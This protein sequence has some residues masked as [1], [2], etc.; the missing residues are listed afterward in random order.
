MTARLIALLWL[1]ISASPAAEKPR[2]VLFLAA[3]DLRCD[4]A[5]Y[6]HPAA[7]TP[8]FDRLA[9]RSVVFHRAY[10]QQALCNPSRASLLTGKR[11]DQ[12]GIWDLPTHFRSS[13][14]NAL[15]I[16]QHFRNHGWF[17]RNLGKIFHNFHHDT[18]GD[19]ASWSVPAEFH[20]G[21]HSTD[22]PQLPDQLPPNLASDPK[23]ECRDIP[24]DTLIDGRIAAAAV[25]A[26]HDA[27]GRTEPTFLAVGFW[28]PHAPFNA[29]KRYWDLYR[30]D[31]LPEIPA[32]A[33]PQHAPAIARHGSQEILGWQQ[34]RSLSPDAARELRHGYL[35]AISFLD[36]Q[37][38]RIL[39]AL[40]SS[41]LASQTIIALWSDH[42]FHLGEHTL[43]GK[44]SNFELDARVPLLIAA[45]GIPAAGSHSLA[46]LTDLFPTLTELSGLPTPDG[47]AGRS[48]VPVLRNP[49]TQVRSAALTQHPRPSYYNLSP[50]RSPTS[51][52]YSL[53]TERFRY[54]EWRDWTTGRT[55][56][57]ELYDHSSD[58]LE[59]INLADSPQHAADAAAAAASL[60][61]FLPAVHQGW[62]PPPP[63]KP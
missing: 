43:W 2:L 10:C 30:R 31:R 50:S 44:T 3:D 59:T 62:T 5:C 18:M 56:H 52:G 14:P 47:L 20:W 1:T 42:G 25:R 53:R 41:G 33:W 17:T 51:M 15:T 49:A 6:G 34:R 21:Q 28:K 54:T 39:D 11:P 32:P 12:L 19:P 48:L 61:T 8:N 45:Q 16:P 13:H 7:R 27:A 23:C 38:G 57:R 35:A 36:A 60:L 26:I 29:P 46:E 58:P 40:D 63:Q 9:Q 37:L 4:L 22:T 24:D 55:S